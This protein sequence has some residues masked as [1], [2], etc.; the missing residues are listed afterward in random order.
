MSRLV[1]LN[2]GRGTLHSGFPCVTL[3]L[4]EEGSPSLEQFVGSLPAA[5]ELLDLYRQ[6]Q[7]LYQLLYEARSI[8]V[9]RGDPTAKTTDG[10]EDIEIDEAD[11]THVSDAEFHQVCQGFQ[12]RIDNWLDAAEFRHLERHLRMRL[13]PD[14]EIRFAIQGSDPQVK[15]LPWHLWQFFQDYPYA[16]ISLASL[17]FAPQKQIRN[18]SH[19]VRILAILADV[20]NRNNSGQASETE[21]QQQPEDFPPSTRDC[22]LSETRSGSIDVAADR[23]LLESLP[24]AEVV[25]LESPS[26]QEVNEY[27]WDPAGWDILFFAGHSSSQGSDR[28]G[29]LFV[30]ERESLT[31]EQLKHALRKAIERGLQVAIFNSCDGLGLGENLASLQI[32]HTIVMREPVPDRV[33]QTFLRFFLSGFSQ[34][35]S[36][37]TAV[38][39]AR[40]RL[41]GVEGEYPCA[42]WLPVICQNPAVSPPTWEVLRGVVPRSRSVVP[43]VSASKVFKTALLVAV[44]VVGVRSLGWLQGWELNHFD[45]MMRLRPEEPADDRFLIVTVDEKDIQYQSERGME[46]RG[47]L[48]DE[49]LNQLL[50]KI[51][52]YDPVAIGSDIIHDFPYQPQLAS[53]LAQMPEFIGICRVS[54]S[55]SNLI[56][57]QPPP[58]FDRDRLGFTN[59]PLDPDRVIR[60]QLLGMS[61]DEN[62]PVNISFSYRLAQR[63]LQAHGQLQD[64]RPPGG[65][66][67]IGDLALQKLPPNAGGYQLEPQEA[68]GYQILLNYRAESPQKVSLQK[69]LSGALDDRLQEL[70]RDRI[71]LI[72]ISAQNRDLHN[73]PYKHQGNR[74]MTGIEIHAQMTSQLISAVL[75]ERPLLWWWPQWVEVL[76]IGAWAV[77]GGT[78]VAWLG[79]SPLRGTLV[80]VATSATLY[81]IGFVLYLYGGW[82][83]TIPA[84]L[85]CAITGVSIISIAKSG[86]LLSA[87]VDRFT[88]FHWNRNN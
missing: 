48:S 88:N 65:N 22:S 19:S 18:Q 71:V 52:P 34:G 55:S 62:C 60:R 69:I 9:R 35:Q 87:G 13:S 29:H 30:N 67:K 78:I 33:A 6:W 46:R 61:P 7:L 36:F 38:R 43:R 76:W 79:A 3:W 40:E 41:Q 58:N 57:V 17:E 54:H 31:V 23:R 50:Q 53:R 5:P 32:P 11:I 45:R 70:V 73:T 51:A 66:L 44:S 84:I 27:L 26:R 75:E 86:F 12:Q 10:D 42:S 14:E 21:N 72:G 64:S 1:V 49:A 63:Y 80:L 85:A 15:R 2:L 28:T 68:L 81:G 59:F 25:V 56:G 16:E 8:D 82:V 20:D 37:Y 74:Q 4:Q 24:H 83:P 77:V 39:E 47:S